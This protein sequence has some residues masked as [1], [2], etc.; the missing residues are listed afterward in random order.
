MNRII[1]IFLS[2][3]F[4]ATVC[5]AQKPEVARILLTRDNGQHWGAFAQG[6]PTNAMINT[7]ITVDR[8][9]VI[10]T[11]DHGIFKVDTHDDVWYSSNSGLP[12]NAKIDALI[13]YR[14]ILFAAVNRGG[15]YT[16]TDGGNTWK[17][18]SKDLE[19][20]PI[21]SFY[22]DGSKLFCGTDVGIF[23]SDDDGRSWAAVKKGMQV[24][25]FVR[26]GSILFAAT[27]EG[28]LASRD[29][30]ATWN[31]QWK[32]GA[33]AR[34]VASGDK[35]I[36]LT[37]GGDV[38]EGP[39]PGPM[40]FATPLL[41]SQYIVQLTPTSEKILKEPWMKNFTAIYSMAGIGQALSDDTHC[42][43]MLST[44]AGLLVSTYAR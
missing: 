13:F 36:G 27:H 15:I 31:Y 41:E 26:A 12:K 29:H 5:V 19:H 17:K 16:S 21:R 32:N 11:N 24:N 9:I 8:S 33:I 38:V 44:P 14:M 35:V 43:L 23:K 2:V 1:A 22:T 34:L 37:Y 42:G 4:S 39:Y 7:W 30:G 6:L 25:D 3:I 28:V 10:G 40:F 18:G 20:L